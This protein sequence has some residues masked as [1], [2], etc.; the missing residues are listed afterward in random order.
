MPPRRKSKRKISVVGR[1]TPAQRQARTATQ[2]IMKNPYYPMIL[3]AIRAG[4]PNSKIAEWCISRGLM[5]VNQK[6]AV[7]YLQYFRKTQPGLCKPQEDAELPGYDHLF[8]GN[9]VMIDEEVELLKLISLQKARIGLAFS[10]ERSLNMVM[11]SNRREVEELRELLMALAKMRGLVGNRM[12]VNLHGY[13]DTV[14]DDL[15][16]I[17]QD[18]GHRNV[19]ATLVSDLAQMEVP[20]G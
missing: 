15:K 3:K 7:G 8:D 4:T 19:I 2:F 10:N 6:T 14:K 13:S 17:Q 12:D 18:E 9:S 16:G 20:D 5:D 1:E 11:T